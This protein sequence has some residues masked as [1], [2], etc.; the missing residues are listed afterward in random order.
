MDISLKWLLLGKASDVGNWV[1]AYLDKNM[2]FLLRLASAGG[3]NI[4][5]G[6]SMNLRWDEEGEE[7]DPLDGEMEEDMVVEDVVEV[8]LETDSVQ[9]L[10][11]ADMNK[12]E[13]NVE[14][15]FGKEN[16]QWTEGGLPEEKKKKKFIS[17]KDDPLRLLCG[18]WFC[19]QEFSEWSP[20]HE[21]VMMTHLK[22][23]GLGLFV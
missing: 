17:L 13:S 14:V 20:F 11:D 22:E 7:K 2:D 10:A 21:H 1:S 4:H 12:L 6:A 9:N 8:K 23:V 16:S 5:E 18:W 15:N 19:G 3:S